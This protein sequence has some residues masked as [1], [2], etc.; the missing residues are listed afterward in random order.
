PG[1]ERLAGR[2]ED[3]AFPVLGD[4]DPRHVG[5]MS[6]ADATEKG[7]QENSTHGCVLH[8]GLTRRTRFAFGYITRMDTKERIQA[9]IQANPNQMTMLLAKQLGVPEVE[10]IREFPD[11]RAIELD[12]D[13]WEDVIRSLEML[14]PVQVIV[15]NGAA[16]LEASGQFG[17][18][19]TTGIFF[20]VQTD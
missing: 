20:N 12:A 18:F 10:V 8:L 16:T 7:E 13:R 17:G 4:G 15:S 11:D 9:A 3:E 14:G 19:S 1:R 2:V 6:V 5:G